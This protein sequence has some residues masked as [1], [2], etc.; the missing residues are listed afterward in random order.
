MTFLFL[1][2]FLVISRP[3]DDEKN[4]LNK[5]EKAS[6]ISFVY[7]KNSRCRRAYGRIRQH[8]C[9]NQLNE[10]RR[11]LQ[12]DIAHIVGVVGSSSSR[13]TLTHQLHF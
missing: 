1:A 3:N 2:E 8:F 9:Q 7:H 10:N 12:R 13:I 6:K 11:K 5:L 4:K